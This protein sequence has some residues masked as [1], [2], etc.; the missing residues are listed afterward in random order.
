MKHSELHAIAHNFA[1]SL[2]CG[3][4]F[5]IGYYAT[6]IFGD[7]S[8]SPGSFLV[9]DFL[10]GQLAEGTASE[11][12]HGALPIFRNEFENFCQKHGSSASDFIEFTTRFETGHLGN[13]YIVTIEDAR[14]RKSSIE[15]EGIPG[16]RAKMRNDQR[17]VVPNKT[18]LKR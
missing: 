9:V 14:G 8:S 3:H 10:S 6:D 15:Y 11:Q 4:G 2:A 16:R 18:V 17:R 1:D 13:R 7:A 12:L 5:V